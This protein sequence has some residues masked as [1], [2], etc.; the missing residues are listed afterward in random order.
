MKLGMKHP[1]LKYY[2]YK[3]WPCDDL[4]QVYEEKSQQEIGKFTE[5]WLF[6]KKKKKKKKKKQPKGFICPCI[7]VKYHNIQACLLV[8]AKDSGER[9]QDHWSSGSGYLTPVLP[10]Y[11]VFFFVCFFFSK[12]YIS[13]T[14]P[15]YLGLH[16][17][18]L[19]KKINKNFA[20]NSWK[21]SVFLIIWQ[22]FF[23]LMMFLRSKQY[24]SGWGL[25]YPGQVY[26]GPHPLTLLVKG[27]ICLNFIQIA[28]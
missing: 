23:Q 7:G 24:I 13:D 9:L 18:F 27:I 20:E 17:L 21:N 3:S 10:T 6:W 2:I 16:F 15:G 1:C 11:D 28:I 22:Q 4:D 5:Y 8:Y 26:L 19:E 14:Q 12:Q 25:R